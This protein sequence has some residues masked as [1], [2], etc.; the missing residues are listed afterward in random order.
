MPKQISLRARILFLVGALFLITLASGWFSLWTTQ[1]MDTTLMTM[2]DDDV[3]ALGFA[4]D[5]ES[6]LALQSVTFHKI[7]T[8][9][10]SSW[11]SDFEEQRRLFGESLKAAR[12]KSTAGDLRETLNEIES[13]HL[14]FTHLQDRIIKVQGEA[15]GGADARE[16]AE[17]DRQFRALW[18]LCE[19]AQRM[20]EQRIGQ[21]RAAIQAKV[22]LFTILA[23]LLVAGALI[24]GPALVYVLLKKVLDPIREL[25]IETSASD[26]LDDSLDEVKSLSQQV[27]SLMQDVDQ[28]QSEL[29]ISREHLLQSGKLAMVGKLAAGVAHS[30][31]NP[32]TSVK[33]RMF[34]L[35][36]SLK[37]SPDQKEDFDVI[38]DEIRHIDTILQNFLEF[39]R[40]PKLKMQQVSPSDVVDSAIQ[41]LRHR[42]E[43]YG[44]AVELYRKRKLPPIEGDPEQLKE[45]VVNLIINACEAMSEGG[46][47]VIQEEE[48][49]SEPMGRVL[50]IRISDNG[51]GIPESI[52]DRVFQPFFS[53]KEEGTG[54][55]LSIATRIIEDHKGCL[56]LRSRRGKGATFTIT[57]P[58][59]G[60]E[61]WLRS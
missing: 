41:L 55:G 11:L 50:A 34:S 31:R 37:L 52:R 16:H 19:N 32:L 58:S 18:E 29:Q 22:Q 38:S 2:A 60:G 1:R 20:N 45:V 23:F 59:K 33:M 9:E 24:L 15:E 40:P 36:R 4:R 8:R 48:G 5:L 47:I 56:N 7:L 17:L 46:T 21:A 35:G 57:L 10:Q 28:T 27:H 30:I 53:T 6:S 42:I 49:F 54:L 51:P 3:A 44:V 61:A 39:S 13:K 25:M 12:A 43:S 26:A 14:R